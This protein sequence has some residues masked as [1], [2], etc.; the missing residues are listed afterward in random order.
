M[1]TENEQKKMTIQEIEDAIIDLIRSGKFQP[2]EP[3]REAELC[4]MFEVSRTPIREALRLLQTKGIVEYLPRRGVQVLEMTM[5]S[6]KEITDLRIVL[7]SLSV[8][9]AM[10]Y[11]N[12]EHIK[13]LREINHRLLETEDHYEQ[14]EVDWVFH[15]YLAT[16]NGDTTLSQ[17]LDDLQMRQA[18][19]HCRL[20]YRADRVPRSYQEH[21][22]MIQSMEW[23]NTE[24]VVRQTEAHF[25]LSQKLL[26]DK[27]AEYEASHPKQ[28]TKKK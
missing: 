4:E 7:E 9:R 15:R 8:R 13:N 26:C 21:E 25:L 5:D 2:G 20:P 18:L 24:L 12:E 27:L 14:G 6:L 22:T 23:G 16:I 19:I 11:I 1:S 10:E 3:L 28:K 17:Y